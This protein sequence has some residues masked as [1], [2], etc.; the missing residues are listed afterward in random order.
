MEASI[1]FRVRVC[2][3]LLGALRV[4]FFGF[5]LAC[6]AKGVI[7]AAELGYGI[8]IG[9]TLAGSVFYPLAIAAKIIKVFGYF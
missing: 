9:F 1:L 8:L 5:V 4:S 3:V 2:G 7:V 6:M